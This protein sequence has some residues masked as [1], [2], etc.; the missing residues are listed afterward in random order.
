MKQEEGEKIEGKILNA[1]FWIE[2][3]LVCPEGVW[4]KREGG[5]GWEAERKW[6]EWEREKCVRGGEKK[7]ES[8]VR[9]GGR[10]H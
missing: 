7:R 5:Y 6:E 9:G 3:L 1:G 2:M 4:R 8:C 10:W